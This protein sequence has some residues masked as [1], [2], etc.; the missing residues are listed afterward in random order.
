MKKLFALALGLTFSLLA[1]S[2]VQVVPL[3]Q[4]TDPGG[5]VSIFIGQSAGKTTTS[6]AIAGMTKG[7]FTCMGWSACGGEGV[8]MSG[9]IVENTGIGWAAASHLTTGVFNTAVGVGVMRNETTGGN[10]TSVGVDSMG[11]SIG[12]NQSTAIGVGAL[13]Y[14][15][16]SL[17][18]GLGYNVMDSASQ[19][20]AA[21]DTGVGALALAAITTGS[22]N[23]AVGTNALNA[24]TTDQNNVAVGYGA[25]KIQNAINY[26]TLIGFQSGVALTSGA[27]NVFLGG[28]PTPSTCA[29][30]STD[31]IIGYN[32]DCLTTS[33]SN[34]INIGNTLIDYST[35]PT[36]SSGGGTSPS[37]S[38][39]GTHVFKVTEG[40]TGVPTTTLVMTMPAAPVDWV[41]TALDRTSASIT[42]RQS[43]AASTTS[44]TITFSGA[45]A[46][47]D[48]IEFQCGAM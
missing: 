8:G 35:A 11:Q 1:S 25:G 31:I 46:N 20:T 24:A 6:A 10:N 18:T 28:G 12:M 42:S 45:P 29:T 34:E 9:T 33:T 37:V 38:G 48:V 13:K 23:T 5:G 40:A 30:G 26:N 47:S 43:G 32:L 15:S 39:N 22:G 2:Q 41:C 36:V 44:V 14:G 4:V 27:H 17:N 21:N 19:T 16:G 3:R 7:F